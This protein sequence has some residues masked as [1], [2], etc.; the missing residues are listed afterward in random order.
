MSDQ[1]E[2]SVKDDQHHRDSCTFSVQIAKQFLTF[3]AAGI[4][5]LVGIALKAQCPLSNCW[6]WTGASLIASMAFGLFYLMSVVAHVNQEK[7]YDV[8]TMPLKFLAGIQIVAFACAVVLLGVVTLRT[9]NAFKPEGRA[10]SPNVSIQLQ[11]KTI[12]LTVPDS[13]RAL[14]KIAGEDADITLEPSP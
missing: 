11:H 13:K 3:A 5:F 10:D 12:Q 9:I 4:A 7:N 1:G 8:Y 14:V 2:A 6:F